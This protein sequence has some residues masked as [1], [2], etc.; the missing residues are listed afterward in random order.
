MTLEDIKEYRKNAVDILEKNTQYATARAVEQAFG[1]LI[2]IGQ[3]KWERDVAIEQLHELGY[4]FG[5][6]ID[7]RWIPLSEKTPEYDEH[8][9]VPMWVTMRHKDGSYSYVR[10]IKWNGYQDRWEWNNGKTLSDE[11]EIIAW[12][13]IKYPK[14]YEAKG[15]L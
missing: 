7:N 9:L 3:F 14:P 1:A 12:K 5:E 6:K 2:C 10:K 15:E 8:T 11:W 13:K 4:G